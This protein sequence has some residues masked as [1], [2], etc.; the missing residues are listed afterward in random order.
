MNGDRKVKASRRELIYTRC[1]PGDVY[2]LNA[3]FRL[4]E[5]NFN[6]AFPAAITHATV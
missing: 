1:S 2:G 4:A 5:E 6:L 3:K